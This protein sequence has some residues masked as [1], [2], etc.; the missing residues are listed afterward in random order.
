VLLLTLFFDSEAG[1]Q[2]ER[3]YA[4]DAQ[5]QARTEVPTIELI[6]YS[7]S[8]SIWNRFGH[9]ALRVIDPVR[10][11]DLVYSFGHAEFAQLGFAWSYLAQTNYFNLG[12]R[13]WDS[14]LRRYRG[15]NRT[16]ERQRLNLSD[17]Q[18]RSIAERLRVNA[19]PENRAYRYDQLLDNCATRIRDLLDDATG[20]SLKRAA[21]STGLGR[22]YRYFTLDASKGSWR[23]VFILDFAAGSNQELKVDG[24]AELYLPA[25]LR[26]AVAVATV[27]DERGTRPLAEPIVVAFQKRGPPSNQGNPFAVRYLVLAFGFMVSLLV[28]LDG[29]TNSPAAITRLA[30]A[31]LLLTGLL[32]GLLGSGLLLLVSIARVPD[33]AW[34]ETV[35]AWLP[36]DFLL[37]GPGWRWLRSG[38]V[39]LS[40][41][42]RWYVVV[43]LA[44][45]GLVVAARVAGLL[46]QDN[47]AFLALPSCIFAA[48]C[49]LA[50]TAPGEPTKALDSLDLPNGA[51]RGRD[52]LNHGGRIAI[53]EI[54][55]H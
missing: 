36:T 15:E 49:V 42:F 14:A 52:V 22:T 23:I 9:S 53:A 48:L 11:T 28:L 26:E 43:R 37:V 40:R 39:E 45:L 16:I 29:L 1:A 17:T 3:P 30:G 6:S 33:F 44:L 51:K 32:V 4:E 7:I 50:A 21:E 2:A 47:W 34:N 35:F 25:R 31:A 13:T 18:A 27:E 54:G 8:D 5:L 19:L 38:R 10:H 46:T 41:V 20:G 24:W 55:Q 12:V